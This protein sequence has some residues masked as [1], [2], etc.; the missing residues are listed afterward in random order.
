MRQR[1]IHSRFLGTGDAD[2]PLDP[3]VVLTRFQRGSW[4]ADINTTFMNVTGL[5]NSMVFSDLSSSVSAG[6]NGRVF[7]QNTN[8]VQFS[9][10]TL[11]TTA[12]VSLSQSQPQM[13]ER[14]VLPDVDDIRMYTGMSSS[15]STSDMV[16]SDTPPHI[17]VGHQYSTGRA[18][19]TYQVVHSPDFGASQFVI[20]TGIDVDADVYLLSRVTIISTPAA[21][22][23]MIVELEDENGTVISTE[24]ITTNLLPVAIP[25]RP[26]RG[27][28]TQ[29]AVAKSYHDYGGDWINRGRVAA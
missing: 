6:A 11:I 25:L 23:A 1:D 12:F 26:W 8:A 10:A 14:F 9:R 3:W 17:Y 24:T 18:D 20:D 13:V 28:E 29:A 16:S 22:T 7:L 5:L 19:T 21:V 2:A 4:I 15:A 27:L